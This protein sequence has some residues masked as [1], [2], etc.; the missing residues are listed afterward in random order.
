[1]KP[2]SRG[3]TLCIARENGAQ[4]AEKKPLFGRVDGFQIDPKLQAG[5]CTEYAL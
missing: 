4:Q 2:F 5:I 3:N 1:M